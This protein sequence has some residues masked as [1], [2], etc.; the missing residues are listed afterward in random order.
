MEAPFSCKIQNKLTIKKEKSYSYVNVKN[1]SCVPVKGY[2][3]GCNRVGT[4]AMESLSIIISALY[5]CVSHLILLLY[6]PRKITRQQSPASLVP[7]TDGS[8]R[9][10]IRPTILQRS[11]EHVTLYNIILC[12]IIKNL[13]SLLTPAHPTC[14]YFVYLLL[15]TLKGCIL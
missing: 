15:F 9:E 6:T 8:S 1:K 7:T 13:P 3:C 4:A 11:N 2:D 10:Y 12:V 14:L 5:L